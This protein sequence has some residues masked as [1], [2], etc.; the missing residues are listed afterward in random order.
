MTADENDGRSGRSAIFSLSLFFSLSLVT[1]DGVPATGVQWL[2]AATTCDQQLLS[3]PATAVIVGEPMGRRGRPHQDV[4]T[5]PRMRRDRLGP[6]SKATGPF[7]SKATGLPDLCQAKST[8]KP[9]RRTKPPARKLSHGSY[10]ADLP[11]QQ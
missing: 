3:S 11:L 2:L 5:R 7:F 10:P 6:V 1:A 4:G 9:S 8:H